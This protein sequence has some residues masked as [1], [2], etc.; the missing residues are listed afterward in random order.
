MTSFPIFVDVSIV[1]RHQDS[2]QQTVLSLFHVMFCYQLVGVGCNR[3]YDVGKEWH[4]TVLSV[5]IKDFTLNKLQPTTG[6]T[7]R[8]A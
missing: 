3:R 6:S 2:E 1:S 5:S 7:A 8:I 4:A